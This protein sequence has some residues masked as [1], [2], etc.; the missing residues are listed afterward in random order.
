MLEALLVVLKWCWMTEGGD[1]PDNDHIFWLEVGPKL[2][3]GVS[4]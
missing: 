3:H 1:L 2:A 4:T